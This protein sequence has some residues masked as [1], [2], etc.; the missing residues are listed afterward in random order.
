MPSIV[1]LPLKSSGRAQRIRSYTSPV[2]VS[3]SP[4][5]E[6]EKGAEA[7]CATPPAAAAPV[8]ASAEH[9]TV[10]EQVAVAY[11][12]AGVAGRKPRY[13]QA[14]QKGA[15]SIALWEKSVPLL[16]TF[17]PY[18]CRSWRCGGECA[19]CAGKQWFARIKTAFDREAPETVCFLVLTLDPKMWKP[20][21]G[22]TAEERMFLESNALWAKLR[23]RL[24]RLVGKFKFC[25]VVE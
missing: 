4:K 1:T 17:M 10:Q 18:K 8:S 2:S 6:L 9:L 14:C 3:A 22:V 20:K 15:W 16:K 19:R 5:Y 23:K 25:T 7:L 21:K 12:K 11:G 24:T 13:V